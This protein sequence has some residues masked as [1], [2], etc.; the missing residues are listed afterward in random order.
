M[1][2]L[3]FIPHQFHFYWNYVDESPQAFYA[4]CPF[5]RHASHFESAPPAG[6]DRRSV[7]DGCARHASGR[8]RS[9][10]RPYSGQRNVR[11]YRRCLQSALEVCLFG[12]APPPGEGCGPRGR[13]EDFAPIFARPFL[14]ARLSRFVMVEPSRKF[15]S[16]FRTRLV[17]CAT[18][19]SSDIQAKIARN[20]EWRAT[21]STGGLHGQ[22]LSMTL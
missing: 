6:C 13:A 15:D 18:T 2:L 1:A 12:R 9:T 20:N 10:S 21:C 5:R 7:P 4:H 11:F 22:V 14:L 17:L 16:E 3:P 8:A 19:S